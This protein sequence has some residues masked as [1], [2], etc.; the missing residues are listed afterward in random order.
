MNGDDVLLDSVVLIDHFNGV[1]RATDYLADV[2]RVARI[3]AITRAEVLTGFDAE[4]VHPAAQ[5]LDRLEL[6]P[7]DGIL[8]DLA[9]EL[10]RDHGWRLPD[11][12]QAAAARHHDLTLATRNTRDFPPDSLDFVAVPYRLDR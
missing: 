8:A 4:T 6:V 7:I 1:S 10:R 12:L 9:A 5:L 2:G 11:A 3:S